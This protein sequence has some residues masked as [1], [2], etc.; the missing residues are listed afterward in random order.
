VQSKFSSGPK[1]DEQAD[2]FAA[3]SFMSKNIFRSFVCSFVHLSVCRSFVC[4]FVRSSVRSFICLFVR[5]FVR[6]FIRCMQSKVKQKK[7]FLGKR[8]K[9]DLSQWTI[10][11]SYVTTD[12]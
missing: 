1:F 6:S 3:L 10:H 12:Y 11:C 5:L 2:I 8:F 9:S 4:L 7:K